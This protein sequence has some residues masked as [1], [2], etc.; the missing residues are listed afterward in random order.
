MFRHRPASGYLYADAFKC[1]DKLLDNAIWKG[2][3]GR[4]RHLKV[5]AQ[6]LRLKRLHAHVRRSFRASG[7]ANSQTL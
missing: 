3:T 1:L 5:L 6:G 2:A 4:K 7:S